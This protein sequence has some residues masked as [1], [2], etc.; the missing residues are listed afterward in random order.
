[1]SVGLCLSQ[2]LDGS[3]VMDIEVQPNSSN[4]GLLGFNPWRSRLTVA[5][6]AEA[7]DGM[8]NR[9]VVHVLAKVLKLNSKALIITAGHRSRF[10]S[11]RIEGVLVD[12]MIRRIE[13]RLEALR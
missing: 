2:A 9:A 4:Q 13:E 1:M 7:K 12:E 6:R 3:V 11:V 10:K 8:A 5:V